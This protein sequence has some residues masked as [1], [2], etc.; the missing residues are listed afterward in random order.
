MS[1]GNTNMT[2]DDKR[3]KPVINAVSP[4]INAVKRR[5]VVSI[6]RTIKV[7]NDRKSTFKIY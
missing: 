6:R 2:L 1:G 3:L 5:N 7:K 4:R